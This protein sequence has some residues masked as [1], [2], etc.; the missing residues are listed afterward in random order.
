MVWM[1]G[2]LQLIIT[3]HKISPPLVINFF[4]RSSFE[5]GRNAGVITYTKL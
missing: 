3:V 1:L 5:P 2:G 4:S